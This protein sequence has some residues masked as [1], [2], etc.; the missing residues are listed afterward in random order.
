MQE[1]KHD[2][3]H[4]H[5]GLAQGLDHFLDGQA[6]KRR[7]VVGNHIFEL[8][9]CR[10][11]RLHLFEPGLDRLTDAQR[12][13]ACRQLHTHGRGGL[14][15]EGG[16]DVVAVTAQLQ[17]RDIAQQY[18]GAIAAGLDHHIAKLFNGLQF[19]AGADRSVQLLP[20]DRRQGS[21]L[22]GGDLS[23]LRLQGTADIRRHQCVFLQQGRVQP[24]PH[25]VA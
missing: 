4:Q 16:A 8:H 10:V 1:H 18:H 14:A 6:D 13:G 25:G 21:E 24:D 17:G 20:L 23:V 7:G 3:H 5:D 19:A 15:V 11:E 9:L 22:P 2:Q 12:I